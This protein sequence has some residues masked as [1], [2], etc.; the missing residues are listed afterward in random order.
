ML[1]QDR[2]F[3]LI[4]VW[5]SS[6]EGEAAALPPMLPLDGQGTMSQV[7]QADDS[8]QE[9]RLQAGDI[10]LNR[11]S[12]LQLVEGQVLGFQKGKLSERL[13]PL[14]EVLSITK[15]ISEDDGCVMLKSKSYEATFREEYFEPARRTFRQAPISLAA[16]PKEGLGHLLIFDLGR[17]Y[18]AILTPYSTAVEVQRR[19]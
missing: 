9:P 3:L 14:E 10:N 12:I 11:W 17:E 2:R 18:Y 7:W 13:M 6:D 5:R 19:C 16:S 8:I 4:S 15:N 1:H